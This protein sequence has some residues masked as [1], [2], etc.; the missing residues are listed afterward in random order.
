MDDMGFQSFF[1]RKELLTGRHL[2]YISVW[3]CL[4]SECEN[5]YSV[6]TCTCIRILFDTRLAIRQNTSTTGCY[7]MVSFV[8]TIGLKKKNVYTS[9]LFYCIFCTSFSRIREF[10]SSSLFKEL[11]M[12]LNASST[13][14]YFN[15]WFLISISLFLQQFQKF[16]EVALDYFIYLTRKKKRKAEMNSK[17]DA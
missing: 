14:M 15:G 10:Y 6:C 17:F 5:L 9:L 4:L 3:Q 16:N 1:I 7:F 12:S 11:F 8:L 13:R 2:W